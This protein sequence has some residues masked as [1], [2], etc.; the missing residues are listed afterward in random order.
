MGLTKVNTF[1]ILCSSFITSVD[2]TLLP[3]KK[4][5]YITHLAEKANDKCSISVCVDLND[6]RKYK[7]SGTAHVVFM[8]QMDEQ[9]DRRSGPITRPGFAKAT[10]VMNVELGQLASDYASY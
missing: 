2:C 1:F 3:I 5:I 10:L 8:L 4:S 7:M 9:M 6:V